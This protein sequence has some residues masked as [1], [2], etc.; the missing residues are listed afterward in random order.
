L[1]GAVTAVIS[2][3]QRH[4]VCTQIGAGQP[5]DAIR[6]LLVSVGESLKALP[7]EIVTR[8]TS[9]LDCYVGSEHEP[10]LR[11]IVNRLV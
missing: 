3:E 7:A 9:W 5:D 8:M 6:G 4:T 1:M 10:Q 2:G 11:T